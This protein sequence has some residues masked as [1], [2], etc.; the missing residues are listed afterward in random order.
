MSSESNILPWADQSPRHQQRPMGH[1]RIG[2]GLGA[3]EGTNLT[4]VSAL[5]K[6]LVTIVYY[7]YIYYNYVSR[8][9]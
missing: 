6:C 7:I 4:E 5:K 1:G 8:K 2:H 9:F 3:G